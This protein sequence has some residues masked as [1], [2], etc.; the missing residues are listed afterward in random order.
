[1]AG[2]AALVLGAHPAYTPAQVRTALVSNAD[3]G[4]VESAGT[5]SPNKL[6]YTGWLDST[7]LVSSRSVATTCGSFTSGSNVKIYQKKT[8]GSSRTVAD[9]AGK[10][11]SAATVGVHVQDSYRGSLTVLLV[12]PSGKKHVLKS[13]GKADHRSGISTTYRVNL[14]AAT[15]AGKWTLQVTDNYGST[16]HIDSWS[17]KL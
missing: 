10:A 12:D 1:V 8:A 7:S 9:C 2:A 17:L 4:I 13:A 15:K 14:S 5:G 3:S 16:G 6:L 11:S